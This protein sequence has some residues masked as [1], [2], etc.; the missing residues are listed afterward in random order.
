MAT[1]IYVIPVSSPSRAGAAMVRH[2]RIPH[3]VVTLMPG[4]HPV[5]VRLAGFE[6]HT[7]PALEVDGVQVQGSCRIAR[8]LDE[9]APDPPLYP[10]DPAARARVEE[11]EHWG[12]RALQPV[13]RRLFR[14]LMLTRRSARLWMGSEVMGIPAAAA[15]APLFMPAIRRLAEISHA[16]EAGVRAGIESLPALL[17]RVD[18]LIADG[19][20][21][22]AAPNAADF[23]ILSSVRVLLEFEELRHLLEGRPCAPAARLLFPD[24]VGPM[25]SGLPV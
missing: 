12:E 11:A 25:P 19:T 13:P 23:Q 17:D 18:A 14:Y 22:G 9:L 6:R 10:S 15:L 4:L 1:R 21:G 8:F 3:R 20:I 2:K 16:D 5:L 7:V 24:W